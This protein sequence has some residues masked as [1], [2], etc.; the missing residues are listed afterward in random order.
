MGL[1][2]AGF[3]AIV[4]IVVLIWVFSLQKSA[5]A[6]R[7]ELAR[8]EAEEAEKKRQAE[9][10][11]QLLRKGVALRCM[12]CGAQFRGP[13]SDEGCPKCHIRSLVVTESE[14]RKSQQENKTSE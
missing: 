9:A 1:V 10:E 6:D 8:Q 12:G 14:Y 4:V 5:S 2:M 13:L 3:L 11:A 7:E